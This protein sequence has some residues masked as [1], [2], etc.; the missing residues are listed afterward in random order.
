MISI[1]I[2]SV[3]NF[4]ENQIN[5]NMYT[6]ISASLPKQKVVMGACNICASSECFFITNADIDD[7]LHCWISSPSCSSTAKNK[8]GSLKTHYLHIL[9]IILP[10]YPL[11]LS[12]S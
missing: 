2:S 11:F 5:L 9:L 7:Y 1:T 4:H 10:I 12:K 3:Q 6:P 8:V